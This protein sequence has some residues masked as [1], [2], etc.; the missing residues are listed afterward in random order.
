MPD[1]PLLARCPYVNDVGSDFSEMNEADKQRYC[2]GDYV[3]CGRYISFQVRQQDLER[4]SP[5]HR[6]LGSQE[7]QID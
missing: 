3:W 4:N 5:S 7:T 2:R 1:C 6:R